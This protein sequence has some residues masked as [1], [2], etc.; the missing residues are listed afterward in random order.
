MVGFEKVSEKIDEGCKPTIEDYYGFDKN[1]RSDNVNHPSHYEL[2][3]LG[4]E[5]IDV[6]RSILGSERFCGYCK[7]NVIKYI[8]RA[9]KKNH[10][11]DLEKARVYLNWL[12]ETCKTGENEDEDKTR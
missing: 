10:L 6:I 5:V 11:E 3:G 4:V 12:I 2:E 7:G 8:L 1:Y 9:D